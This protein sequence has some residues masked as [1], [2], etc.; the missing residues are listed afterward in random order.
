D[1]GHRRGALVQRRPPGRHRGQRGRPRPAAAAMTAADLEAPRAL[2]KPGDTDAVTFAWADR[3]AGLCGLAR[4]AS[5]AG[6]GGVGSHSALAIAFAGRE[7]LGAIAESGAAPPP[8]LVAETLAPLERWT[9]RGTGE[10][11]FELQ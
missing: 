3:H 7:T 6:P 1:A 5:G 9:L 10:L 4:V 11:E 8:Q 2:R